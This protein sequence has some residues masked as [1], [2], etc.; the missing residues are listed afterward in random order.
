MLWYHIDLRI[1]TETLACSSRVSGTSLG[2]LH[3]RRNH[4]AVNPCS[5]SCELLLIIRL[6]KMLQNV[7]L[8]YMGHPNIQRSDVLCSINH[9]RMIHNLFFK[10][11]RRTIQY[12]IPSAYSEAS[13]SYFQNYFTILKGWLFSASVSACLLCNPA[14][15]VCFRTGGTSY[16]IPQM[17]SSSILTLRRCIQ[18]LLWCYKR[19]NYWARCVL[20][21]SQNSYCLL[22]IT[23]ALYSNI[24][25]NSTWFV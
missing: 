18:L 8:N 9:F 6:F 12:P 7:P 11:G 25:K 21:W 24:S 10:N 1:L 19:M 22:Y 23:V 15:L 4:S 5:I 2:G 14:G 17:G 20:L 3:W 16:V 13:Y